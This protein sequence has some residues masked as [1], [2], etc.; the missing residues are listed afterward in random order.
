MKIIIVLIVAAVAVMGCSNSGQE[1][2]AVKAC[3]NSGQEKEAVKVP[4][5]DTA[6]VVQ[7]VNDIYTTV[8]DRYREARTMLRPLRRGDFDATFCSADWNHW[9]GRVM[10]YDKENCQGMVGFFEADHWIMGQDWDD[11]SV[12]DVR[13]TAMTASTASVNFN[14]HNCG[15]VKA[16]RLDMVRE[17]DEL[18]ID[19]FV[20]VDNG[21]DWKAKMKAYMKHNKIPR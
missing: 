9:L 15:S 11:L 18:K 16:V 10:T 14:L 13:V 5:L 6:T 19:D 1:K 7:R 20:D 2:E 12:S 21:I 17:G 3:S 8:F 4:P